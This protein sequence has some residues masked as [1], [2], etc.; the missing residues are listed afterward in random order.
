[1]I[2]TVRGSRVH[3]I[4]HTP[5]KNCHALVVRP[6]PVETVASWAN[7]ELVVVFSRLW[8]EAMA[9]QVLGDGLQQGVAIETTTEWSN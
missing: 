9:D 6:L 7:V 8:R 1:M 2:E 3:R 5:D 4:N